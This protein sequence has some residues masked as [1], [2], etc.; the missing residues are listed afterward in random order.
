MRNALPRVLL[1]QDWIL[2]TTRDDAFI[3]LNSP[4]FDPAQTVILEESLDPKPVRSGGGGSARVVRSST[5]RLIVE[6]N[7]PDPAI[8]LITDAYSTGWRARPLHGSDQESYRLMPADYVLMAVPLSAGRHRICIEYSPAGFRIGRW[9][10]AVSGVVL[11]ILLITV[12]RRREH[13]HA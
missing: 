4:G 9:I 1:A 10:S 7:T 3:A 6:V 13:S 2:R 5:D 11:L 8:L 12:A